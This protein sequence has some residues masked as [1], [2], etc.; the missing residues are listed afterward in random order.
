[1]PVF[2]LLRVFLCLFVH[3]VTE[4]VL[5]Q[6]REL[7]EIFGTVVIVGRRA[8]LFETRAVERNLVSGSHQFMDAFV[9]LL[10]NPLI[11]F[12]IDRF[13]FYRGIG[14][15]GIHMLQL[16]IQFVIIHMTSFVG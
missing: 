10:Q 15:K 2:I 1:M 9:L 13:F 5:G 11:V 3:P 8:A 16:V 4:L 12:G 14:C 6:E 7:I